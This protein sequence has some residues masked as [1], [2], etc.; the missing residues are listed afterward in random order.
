MKITSKRVET[1]VPEA[2]GPEPHGNRSLPTAE[3]IVVMI[4]HPTQEEY[5][6]FAP[7]LTNQFDAV[8]LVKNFVTNIRNLE[9]E[10]GTAIDTGEKLVTMAPRSVTRSLI[11]ELVMTIVRGYGIPEDEEKN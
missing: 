4:K 3:K 9:L 2:T 11:D 10:D 6:P 1:Y 5:E 8:G 7:S